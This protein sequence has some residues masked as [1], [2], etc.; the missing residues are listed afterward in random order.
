[1]KLDS[2]LPSPSVDFDGAKHQ[3]AHLLPPSSINL[4]Y[5]LIMVY[6]FFQYIHIICIAINIINKIH[7]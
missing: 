3:I 7:T 5:L 4:F 1:M 2:V 6:C